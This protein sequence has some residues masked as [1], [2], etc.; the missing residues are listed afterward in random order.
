MPWGYNGTV[1]T[2]TPSLTID[3]WTLDAVLNGIGRLKEVSWG[4]EAVTS[5]AMQTR[6]ARSNG[7]VGAQNLGD[8]AKLEGENVPANKLDF[9]DNVGYATTHPTLEAADLI[10]ES[11]NAHGGLLRWLADPEEEIWLFTGMALDLISCRNSV[12]V[13]ASSYS[14][15][16]LE[17]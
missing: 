2:I 11:W 12:G 8:V 5:T 14:V 7:E 9:N 15:K 17:I 10:S 13:A 1:K 16:W 3:N 4:G 6:V